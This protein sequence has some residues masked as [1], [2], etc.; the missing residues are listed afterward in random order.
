MNPLEDLK[1]ALSAFGLRLADEGKSRNGVHGGKEPVLLDLRFREGKDGRYQ[2]YKKWLRPG[3]PQI[4]LQWIELHDAWVL[5]RP[6]DFAKFTIANS[7]DT[8]SWSGDRG[9]WLTKINERTRRFLMPTNEVAATLARYC[10][11]G[12]EPCPSL[13]ELDRIARGGEDP[14]QPPV[15]LKLVQTERD[16]RESLQ[17]FNLDCR[18]HQQRTLTTVKQTS[19]WIYDPASGAYGPSKFVGF[20][21]MDFVKYERATKGQ[22][23]GARFDGSVTW[24]AIARV[25][26]R[27][28]DHDQARHEGLIAW[29]EGLL[30]QGCLNGI[31]TSKWKFVNL[32]E[33]A[34][35]R[36][37]WCL[38]A[39]PQVY[40][41]EKAALT[42]EEDTW[43][44]PHGEALPGDRLIFWKTLGGTK[45]RGVVSLG[46]VLVGP[47]TISAHP[48]SRI[49]VRESGDGQDKR[50]ITFRYVAP[51]KAP[52][53]LDEDTSGLLKDMGM[54]D[55]Q[56]HWLFKV[57]P[58]HWKRL[59]EL[60]GG[61]PETDTSPTA[62]PEELDRRVRR[63]LRSR[64]GKL[65]KPKGQ[66]KPKK[67][68]Q[69]GVSAYERD[70]YVKAWVLQEAKGIC[71]C[72]GEPGP[73]FTDLGVP[74]LEVHHVRWLAHGGPDVIENCVAACPNCHREL[75][76]G[77]DRGG[78]AAAL[79]GRVERL[80]RS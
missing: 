61:W 19:F 5:L 39:N 73:F 64:P 1:V 16:I 79:Y 27:D 58:D 50:R 56:G 6:R 18:D 46:E 80:S 62:D 40:D 69:S 7:V 30:G 57:D 2:I 29:A 35:S 14:P 71:E 11:E 45:K 33:P 52:L 21:G 44:I 4:L 77:R 15:R 47:Q 3:E 55:W 37:Y 12:V 59:M 28:F 67:R 36:R 10:E 74:F 24:N 78:L 70:P 34:V 9:W 41:I 75:H 32:D 66:A 20:Q 53:W 13:E 23:T 17:R 51:D 31:D 65:P 49:F 48:D 26:Q 68:D 63:L 42:I 54:G 60:L 38:L 25:L 8:E 22:S 43:T 72:C 76:L